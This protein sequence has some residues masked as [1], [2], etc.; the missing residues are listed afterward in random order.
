MDHNSQSITYAWT[1]GPGDSWGSLHCTWSEHQQRGFGSGRLRLPLPPAPKLPPPSFKRHKE[2]TRQ[3]TALQPS[4]TAPDLRREGWTADPGRPAEA[5]SHTHL[6]PTGTNPGQVCA[7][8]TTAMAWKP[9]CAHLPLMPPHT[10]CSL[11]R[12]HHVMENGSGRGGVHIPASL[13]LCQTLD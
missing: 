10:F 6:L 12:L 8:H 11:V 4:V 13:T 9:A 1:P 7:G 3:V 5:S 2:R